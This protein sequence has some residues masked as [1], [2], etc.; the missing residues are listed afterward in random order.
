MH[1]HGTATDRE[2]Y[3]MSWLYATVMHE[4]GHTLG[5]RHNFEG[6][7]AYSQAQLHDPQFTRAH[8]KQY[9]A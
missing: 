8:G 1:G 7:T 6:S 4:T 3:T 2:R 5:L 9:D